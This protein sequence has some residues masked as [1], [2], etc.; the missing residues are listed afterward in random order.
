[1]D[2]ESPSER[3]VVMGYTDTP[4]IARLLFKYP[5]SLLSTVTSEV[6]GL[7]GYTMVEGSDCTKDPS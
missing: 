5:S 4:A 2:G 1:M 6:V 7:R 3:G